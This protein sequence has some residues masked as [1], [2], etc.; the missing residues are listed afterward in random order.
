M[1]KKVNKTYGDAP[2]LVS[3]LWESGFFRTEKTQ[4]DV[5]EEL[6]KDGNNFLP[7]TLRK[8][9][10][11]ATYL[12]SKKKNGSIVY[13]Q[14]KHAVNKDIE[15]AEDTLFD[16]ALIK[17]FGKPFEIALSDLRH[18]FGKSGTCTA[19]LLRKILEKLIYITFAK[20]GMESKL[21]DK[22]APGRLIGLE[23]MIDTAAREKVGGLPFITSH[24]A[25]EIK[26]IKFLGDVSAHN[27]H[28]EVDM[29]T[30]IPQ[31]PFIITAYKELLK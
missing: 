27:P 8:V 16:E 22:K 25:N 13:I 15:K 19:F 9:L 29:K 24:T 4:K 7:D 23:A 28:T 12:I 6:A 17:K 3:S 2:K 20:H 26:G 11:R 18:N 14:K 31:L 21:D 5:T 10:I 1:S 30:I